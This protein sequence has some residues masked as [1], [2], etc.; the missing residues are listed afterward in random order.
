M[1][2][3]SSDRFIGLRFPV[4]IA[5]RFHRN[6]HI[7]GIEA[8]VIAYEHYQGELDEILETINNLHKTPDKAIEYS[9][10][11]S[12]REQILENLT[13]AGWP[14]QEKLKTTGPLLGLAFKRAEP[15][16]RQLP[17]YEASIRKTL[18]TALRELKGRQ[19]E[20]TSGYTRKLVMG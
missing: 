6:A 10:P 13:A 14:I 17:R 8:A 20:R 19:A 12:S 7:V 9:P 5:G 2:Q 18:E 1:K 4:G 11:S 3:L 15:T 16:L